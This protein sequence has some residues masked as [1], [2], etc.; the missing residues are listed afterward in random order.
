VFD[1]NSAYF[2]YHGDGSP[3]GGY[4]YAKQFF[5]EAYRLAV[6]E[7]GGE[8]YGYGGTPYGRNVCGFFCVPSKKDSGFPVRNRINSR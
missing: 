3:A 6:N 4:E 8:A 7:A 1:V 2:E 5:A